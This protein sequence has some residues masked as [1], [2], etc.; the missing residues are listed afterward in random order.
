MAKTKQPSALAQNINS[1]LAAGAST[2]QGI[3][4]VPDKTPREMLGDLVVRMNAEQ[5]RNWGTDW[6]EAAKS[7][8]PTQAYNKGKTSAYEVPKTTVMPNLPG[9]KPAKMKNMTS[10][11]RPQA[12]SPV[13]MKGHSGQQVHSL[14]HSTIKAMELLGEHAGNNQKVIES[15]VNK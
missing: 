3:P 9:G 1:E 15:Q 5:G 6:S 12:Q 13:S 7:S 8:N 4:H 11:G 10:L 14:V 2:T